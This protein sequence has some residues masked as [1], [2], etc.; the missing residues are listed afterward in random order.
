MGLV[1]VMVCLPEDGYDCDGNCLNDIDGDGICDENEI[2]GCTDEEANNYDPEATDD[3]DSCE[4]S[5]TVD[6]DIELD[7]GANLISFGHYQKMLV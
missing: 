7:G 6:F 4:Y 3:D 5:S 1:I 2:A